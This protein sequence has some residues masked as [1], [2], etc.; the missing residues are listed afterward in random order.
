MLDDNELQA[1]LVDLESDRVERKESTADSGRIR[2]AI[3]AFANDMAG[4]GQP[5]VVFIG[6]KNDGSCANLPITDQLLLTLFNVQDNHV[7]VIVRR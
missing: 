7:L 1:L 3:C 6:V 2:Q 4:H 5:G